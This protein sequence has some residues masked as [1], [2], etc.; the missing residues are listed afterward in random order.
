MSK[1]DRL[2]PKEELFCQY[3]AR[4]GEAFGNKGRAYAIAFG[5]DFVT[6]HEVS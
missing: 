4:S 3:Y 1:S 6:D 5:K 2:K